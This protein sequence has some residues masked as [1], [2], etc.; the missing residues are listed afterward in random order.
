M[1]GGLSTGY[2]ESGDENLPLLEEME[3]SA[4]PHKRRQ[5]TAI[6]PR[7]PYRF[8]SVSAVDVLGLL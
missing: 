5:E 2:T 7:L 4:L 1:I 3:A 6:R 8:P